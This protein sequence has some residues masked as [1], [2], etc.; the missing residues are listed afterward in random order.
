MLQNRLLQKKV[1]LGLGKFTEKY[2]FSK[3]IA[4]IMNLQDETLNITPSQLLLW[5]G[6]TC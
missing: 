3:I 1:L 6:Y 4:H 5:H 2:R